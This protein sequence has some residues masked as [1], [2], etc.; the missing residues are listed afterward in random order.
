MA[1]SG[2][3]SKFITGRE[4]RIDWSAAQDVAGNCSVITCTHYLINDSGYDLYIGERSNYCEIDGSEDSYTSPSISTGGGSSIELGTTTH[5]VYHNADGTKTAAISATFYIQAYLSGFYVDSIT[6][7]GIIE[8]DRIPRAATITSAPNFTDEDA[9]TVTYSN[10]AGSAVQELALGIYDTAGQT[11]IVGYRDVSKTG[12]SY[13]FTF[14]EAERS[15]LQAF[16]S[17]SKSATVRFYLRTYLGGT[18]YYSSLEKTLTIANAAPTVSLTATDTNSATVALT[19]NAS[20]MVLGKSNARV[21]VTATAKKGASITAYSVTAGSKRA[22]AATSTLNA[23]DGGNFAATATDTRGYQ[24]TAKLTAQTVAYVPLTCSQKVGMPTAAGDCALTIKGDYFNG[25]FGATANTLTVQYRRS[26]DGGATWGSWVTATATKSGNA[27]SAAVTVTGLDYQKAHT[28]QARATDKLGTVT[29]QTKTVKTV[30]VFDWSETTFNTNVLARLLKGC[31]VAGQLYSVG[32]FKTS[33]SSPATFGGS[34]T[35]N[36]AV[37]IG[38]N[39]VGGTI[40]DSGT[41]GDWRYVKLSNGLAVCYKNVSITSA[42]DN[43]WGALYES[44]EIA[45]Q[46]YP[47]TFAQVPSCF[48]ALRQV[49]GGLNISGFESGS[50]TTSA[51][52]AFHL[53]RPTTATSRTWYCALFAVGIWRV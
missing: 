24:V 53:L 20:V 30:P 38:G 13:T 15:A 50:G 9:P 10:A 39:P 3:I 37:T 19:G 36:G 23:V 33:A 25:S 6:A 18:Y 48:A 40:E 34:A 44:A 31:N 43:E 46:S 35:F 51:S 4:Y 16:V 27:Y 42:I 28:F 2:T 8:L 21:V 47:F 5:T 41:S 32:S 17:A 12:G 1:T 29:T 14:T 11:P 52:P 49:S 45:P 22:N 26:E 7:S